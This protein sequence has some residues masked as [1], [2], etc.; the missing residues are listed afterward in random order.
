VT[1]SWCKGHSGIAGNE[2]ADLL[3]DRGRLSIRNA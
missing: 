3:A 2:R 1:I